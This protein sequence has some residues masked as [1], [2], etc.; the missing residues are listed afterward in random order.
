MIFLV[1][2]V[3]Y[4][5]LKVKPHS[6]SSFFLMCMCLFVYKNLLKTN[7]VTKLGQ[8]KLKGTTIT[9]LIYTKFI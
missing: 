2:F 3:V 6:F 1:E 4:F 8:E 5:V 9:L 7:T